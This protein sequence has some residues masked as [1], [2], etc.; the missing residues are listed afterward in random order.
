MP[1]NAN[2]LSPSLINELNDLKRR[3][4]AV[5]RKPEVLAKFDRYPTTE[6]AAIGRGK[7][8]GN[9]WSSCGIA[10]VTGLVYDRLECKFITDK[11]ITGKREAEIRL[12]AFRH[13]GSTKKECVSASRSLK[14]TGSADRQVGTVVMRWLHGIPYGWDY[15]DGSATFTVELQ[16]RYL[17]GPEETKGTTIYTIGADE[18][19]D[20]DGTAARGTSQ[21]NGEWWFSTQFFSGSKFA[22][23]FVT[24]PN[25][26]D[27]SYNIS[28][29]HYCVGLPEDR[30]NMGGNTAWAQTTGTASAWGDA[31][32][33]DDP[34]I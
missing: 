25:P 31:A 7:V 14:L 17:T 11:L 13:T 6:W 26:D 12:A 16:H 18:G 24:I 9:V 29:M 8:A 34:F 33:I 27:G 22:G 10:N 5:E 2:A 1:I 21:E 20:T 23:R 19:A 3:L 15:E 30:A 4:S 28:N 32:N